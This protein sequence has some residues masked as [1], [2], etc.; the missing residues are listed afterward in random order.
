ML[1]RILPLIFLFILLADPSSAIAAPAKAAYGKANE[2]PTF[3]RGASVPAWAMPLA[4]APTTQREDPVVVRLSEIQARVATTPA[5][6]RNRVIQVNERSSLAR[7]GQFSISYLPK[8]QKLALHKVAILRGGA[9][10]DRTLSVNIRLLD[11]ERALEQGVYGGARSAQ[12]LIDDVRVGDAL[13]VVYTVEGENPV[14]GQAWSGEFAIDSDEPIELWRLSVTRPKDKPLYWRQVGDF[15]SDEIKPVI[16]T[17]GQQE[18][19]RFESRGID[20][21]EME[22]AVSPDYF[23]V[24]IIQFSQYADWHGVAVWANSLFPQA[25]R[26]AEVEKLTA[27]FR[28]QPSLE[29]QA[30]EALRWV[31][32]EIRYFSVSIGENSHRPQA[33]D[34]V[35][36]RRY[37]DCKDKSYLLT[38]ILNQLGIRARPVL[39]NAQA[40]K[41]PGKLL[42]TPAWFDHAIVR[43]E[44]DGKPFFVDPTRSGERGLISLRPAVLPDGLGLVVDAASTA[45]DTL[46]AQSL[47]LPSLDIV[48]KIAVPSMDDAG[49][50]TLTQT[51]RAH[52]ANWAREHYAGL[53]ARE[54][55]NELIGFIDKQY[56]GAS[57][58]GEARIVDHEAENV[59]QLIAE[60]A[61]PKPVSKNDG[62]F[63]I[64]YDSKVL[65]GTLQVPGKVT[66]NF[67]LALT[68]LHHRY[69]LQIDWP[70]E[71]RMSGVSSVRTIDNPQFSLH[72]EYAMIGNR[73]DLL[74]DYAVKT[75]KVAAKDVPDLQLASK[76]LNASM[77]ASFRVAEGSIVA[78]EARSLPLRHLAAVRN[79]VQ[80]VEFIRRLDTEQVQR[81]EQQRRQMCATMAG[82]TDLRLLSP[83]FKRM[84]ENVMAGMGRHT[85]E[86]GVRLCLAQLDFA[87][88]DYPRAHGMYE[89]EGPLRNDDVL[90]DELAWARLL[91]GDPDGA[92]EV[93]KRYVAARSAAG[94]L[95]AYDLTSALALYARAK[96]DIPAEL[97]GAAARFGDGPWPRPVLAYQLGQLKQEELLAQA[98]SQPADLR[99]RML[100][101]AWFYIAQ[102]RYAQGD[103][104]AGR[105]ALNWIRMHGIFGSPQF[106]Q[107]LGELWYADY[108]DADYR[109]ARLAEDKGDKQKAIE[110]FQRAAARGHGAALSAL[111]IKYRE[112]D[113][114]SKDLPRAI[115]MFRSA[116]A[117]GNTDAMN[118]LGVIYAEGTGVERSEATALEWY[119]RAA[120]IGDFYASRNIGW[121]H[122]RGTA[123]S[124]QD[125]ALARQFLA[126]SAELGN[127]EA[128]GELADVYLNGEDVAVD[129]T[130]AHYWA[131]RAADGGD[132]HGR[133]I[134]GYLHAYG[135]G[136]K[137]DLPTA[138]ALWQIAA[139]AGDVMAQFQL[140]LAYARG[141]GVERDKSRAR[142]LLGTAAAAGNLYARVYY[143]DLLMRDEPNA[144]TVEFVINSLT[145][146]A[147]AGVSEAAECLSQYYT[148]GIG[149]PKDPVMGAHWAKLAADK[150]ARPNAVADGAVKKTL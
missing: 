114:V 23:P 115:A 112:G 52:S 95:G 127:T 132:A 116:A 18:R 93:S 137:K 38:T 47:A 83:G 138:I 27:T 141:L 109:N 61:L 5:V 9:V 104:E 30:S 123:G 146:L 48:E 79:A 81:D 55:R 4:D 84:L 13:W 17:I 118:A 42:P 97:R 51:Y 12:L 3:S 65:A 99:D 98:A 122:R 121:R 148:G 85:S 7:I 53:S 89:A 15:R 124:V 66:R 56:P 143:G 119:A 78:A 87:W 16:E 80:G 82:A 139:R 133:A 6:L 101:D 75:A 136:V 88:G 86:A 105:A 94:T 96:Q 41:V 91:A 21:V 102:Q 1:M 14:F 11:R 63:S 67:P 140:G 32:D 20:A 28:K 33:P 29:A 31:Q 43:L 19:L 60:Y 113:G 110:L 10:L 58:K 135:R 107:A 106:H 76:K 64:D 100:S 2:D 50:L 54:M 37:G 68:P 111:G 25:G 144:Q 45:L 134:L 131:S 90:L 26:S 46:P 73:V 40:P 129:Y 142:S 72:Q 22:A 130:L 150:A 74:L 57:L 8:H 120:K 126:D 49:L 108:A 39:V 77:E 117:N 35:L 103:A 92:I 125:G 71:V 44:L 24:R 70:G 34:I 145:V 69:R 62:V 147:N 149:V 59:Y 128:Q 36:K